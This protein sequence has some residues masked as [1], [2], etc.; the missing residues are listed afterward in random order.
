MT[1]IDADGHIEESAAMFELIEE[2]YYGRR[3]IAVNFDSN[4]ALGGYNA[5]W[6]IDGKT[7]PNIL[8]KGGSIFVTPTS[9]DRA[10]AKPY[11]I[12]AQELTDVSDRL[13]DLDAVGIDQQVVYPTLFLTT[14]TEDVKLEA[15]LFRAYN[16]FLGEAHAASAGRIRFAAQ[17]P[18]RDV[19]QSI[20][21]MQRARELG[22]AAVM[23]LGMPWGQS[24]GDDD[25]FPFYEEASR[26]DMPVCAHFGWG[27]PQ[28]ADLFHIQQSFSAAA[29]PVVMAFYSMMVSGVLDTFPK[30]RF[31]FLEVGSMWVPHVLHQLQRSGRVQDPGRYFKEG[32]VFVAC[33]ADEDMNYLIN[34]I[35][36]DALV[37][38]SDYPHSDASREENMV[39]AIMQREDVPLAT[40]EK[41]LSTNPARL[42]GLGRE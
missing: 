31:G 28:I 10:K 22:A 18:I 35:G 23:L 36:D 19:G 33:E 13:R 16:S 11:S 1:V 42:Y 34:L 24:L 2:P 14:T 25:L 29:L 37:V 17:V 40:R 39:Q 41:I 12:P 4:T 7:Y 3:P 27:C 21:E 32:R 26:L 5:V 38:A 6:L 30:L 15:A 20:T 9:M 8:G